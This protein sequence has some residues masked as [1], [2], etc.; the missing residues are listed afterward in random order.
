M[1]NELENI[2]YELDVIYLKSILLQSLVESKRLT[3]LYK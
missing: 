3:V 2:C 1:K